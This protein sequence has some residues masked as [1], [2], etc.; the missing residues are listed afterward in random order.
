MKNSGASTEFEP[1]ASGLLLDALLNITFYKAVNNLVF[2]DS[3]AL[4]VTRQSTRFTRSSSSSAITYIPK[5]NRTVTY[6]ITAHF[7]YARAA[8]GMFCPLSYAQITSL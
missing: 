8:H 5:L 6:D 2:I 7:S 4:P 1:V 3:E